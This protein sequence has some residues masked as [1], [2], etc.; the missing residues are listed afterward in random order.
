VPDAGHA[1]LGEE[2]AAQDAHEQD[3]TLRDGPEAHTS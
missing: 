1:A 3:M 2:A